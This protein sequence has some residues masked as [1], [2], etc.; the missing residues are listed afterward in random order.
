MFYS[1]SDCQATAGDII[2]TSMAVKHILTEYAIKHFAQSKCTIRSAASTLTTALQ[3]QTKRIPCFVA[4]QSRANTIP[5]AL[6]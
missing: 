4:D 1:G 3:R 5:F 2:C 6:H